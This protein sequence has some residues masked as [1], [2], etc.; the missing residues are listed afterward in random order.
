MTWH[1]ESGVKD[2]GHVGLGELQK[3]SAWGPHPNCKLWRRYAVEWSNE[4]G[5]IDDWRRR[6]ADDRVTT[7]RRGVGGLGQSP[8]VLGG[9]TVSIKH[10]MGQSGGRQ[11]GKRSWWGMEVK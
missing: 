8:S 3:I 11:G 4:G 10:G 6:S 9:W 5:G 2:P 7:S 1:E